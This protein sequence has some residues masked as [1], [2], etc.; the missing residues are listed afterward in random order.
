MTTDRRL[1]SQLP[2]VLEDLATGPYPDYIDDVL[3]RTARG[4]QRPAWTFPE[5]WLPMVELARQPAFVPRLPWRSISVALVLLALLLAAAALL[6]G[7]QRRVPEPFGLARNGLVAYE[8]GGDIYT[9]DPVT[10]V[11]TAIVSGPDKDSDPR[12]SLD[13]TRLV[14]E[15]QAGIGLAQ[16]YVVPSGGGELTLLT[17]EPLLLA[18]AGFGRMWEKYEFS[19]D[20]TSVL[21]ALSNQ[22][23]P[24]IA[25]ARS[26]G[27]GIRHL[28]VGL[29]ASEPSYRP[30]DGA[31]IL[32][33]GRSASERGLF[34]VDSATGTVRS[35]LRLSP[36][37][38]LAGANWSP[39]GS[40]IAYWSWS[41]TDASMTA[42]SHVIAA[43]GTGN[44]PLPAPSDAVWDAHSTWSNDGTRIFLVRGYTADNGDVRAVVLP[45]DGSSAGTEIAAGVSPE[46][47]CCAAWAW[48]PDDSKILGR[49][50]NGAVQ[51]LILDPATGDAGTAPWT[52]GSDPTWQ[53]LAP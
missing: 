24:G 29:P 1:T 27:S 46:T 14:F 12:F 31:E 43:D 49:A 5:R 45:A 51:Q 8:A 11:A 35:I 42:K 28:D 21:I 38:D 34:A 40:R 47:G 50:A 41:T 6:V 52:S 25:I 23:I 15:R 4:R 39:D 36:G 32:F 33:I 17:P 48:S 19:P 13:G 16:L 10:G 3:T 30:P 2:Q 37:Y 22:G 53:R 26:D 9:A 44:K 18:D 7:T 20:G